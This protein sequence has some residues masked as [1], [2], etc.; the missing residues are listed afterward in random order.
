MPL[1]PTK[2]RMPFTTKATLSAGGEGPMGVPIKQDGA[3][4]LPI[5]LITRMHTGTRFFAKIIKKAYATQSHK[6]EEGGQLFYMNHC[7]PFLMPFIK[8]RFHEGLKIITTERSNDLIEASWMER[9]GHLGNDPERSYLGQKLAWEE[10][11][12]PRASIVV[13][14]DAEDREARLKKLGDF[15]GVE[16]TTD[17]KPI[18]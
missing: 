10:W 1:T 8:Q 4:F 7:Q 17:W 3:V 16:L 18:R 15:L 11:I 13:S 9:Y 6:I 12:L 5:M 14:V 2:R